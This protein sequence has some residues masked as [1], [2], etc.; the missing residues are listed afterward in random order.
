MRIEDSEPTAKFVN[1]LQELKRIKSRLPGMMTES[2]RDILIKHGEPVILDNLI[3]VKTDK[4]ES[5][6]QII[7]VSY[8]PEL[9]AVMLDKHYY[10][11]WQNLRKRFVIYIDVLE[12]LG[13]PTDVISDI[14][15][16]Y[17]DC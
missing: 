7:E 3:T 13:Y 14:F 11:V 10:F 2:L 8:D 12:K 16:R 1:D 9:D 5:Y 15:Y 4:Y 6:D 17:Y